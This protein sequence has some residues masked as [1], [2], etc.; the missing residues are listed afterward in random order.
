MAK[1]RPTPLH[2]L[3]GQQEMELWLGASD[4]GSSFADERERRAA[5][6]RH[7]GR[8][9]Q[10]F[11]Q[12]GKRPVA[13]WQYEAPGELYYP[14]PDYER[15]TLYEWGLLAETERDELVVCWRRAAWPR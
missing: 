2:T 3:T 4:G 15:S 6:F 12:G 5:W 10:L 8:L 13:W 11:A 14:G 7:R 1:R 9:M